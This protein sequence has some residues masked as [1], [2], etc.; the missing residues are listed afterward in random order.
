MRKIGRNDPCPCGSGRK[1]K[2][3]CLKNKALVSSTIMERSTHWNFKEIESFTTEQI[4]H[5]LRNLGILFEEKQFLADI[6]QFYSGEDLAHHW[7][8]TYSITAR[9]FDLD[10]IWM[11]SIVLWNRLAPDVINSEKLDDMMQHGY[12]LLRESRNTEYGQRR[13]EACRIWLEVWEHLKA[14]FSEE[15]KSIND[16]ER[17]FRGMQ[18]LFNWCQDLEMELHNAGLEDPFFFEKRI[19]YCRE[20]CALFPMSDELIIHN[21][22]RSEG[23]SYFYLGKIEQ[24]DQVFEKLI[25]DYPDNAWGYIGW[26]DM[27]HWSPDDKSRINYEKAEQIYRKALEREI[28]DRQDVID[29]LEDLENTQRVAEQKHED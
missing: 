11:A 8:E 13:V 28:D 3:C 6:K 15:M 26:G 20:F 7:E 19:T 29:R 10:F 9:G 21:M 16:A 27:Y 2:K 22:R 18:S 5:K 17:V 4:I 23:E 12:D 1:F 25:R 24:G 14:R